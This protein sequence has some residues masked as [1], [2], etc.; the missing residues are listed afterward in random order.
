MITIISYGLGNIRAFVNAYERLHIPISVAE[1][2][3]DLRVASKI[4]LPGVGAFDYAMNLLHKSGMQEALEKIVLKRKI[5]ILGICVGMQMMA[6]SSEEGTSPGLG[7]I[8]GTVRKFPDINSDTKIQL[9]H[10]GWNTIDKNKDCP[11]L[12]NLDNYSRFYFLHSYCF[13]CNKDNDTIATSE[14]NIRF[15][16]ILNYNNI[17]GVQFHPEKSHQSGIQLLKNFADL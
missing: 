5:P 12:I 6:E 3:D 17:F 15:T 4:I 8:S 10:M 13:H 9:P 7:W 2:V 14:Y 1:T 11:L 16:S